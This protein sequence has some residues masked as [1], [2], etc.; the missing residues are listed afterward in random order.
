[1]QRWK[2][3]GKSRAKVSSGKFRRGLGV[4]TTELLMGESFYPPGQLKVLMLTSQG[5]VPLMGLQ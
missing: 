5:Q 2:W 1:M 4:S 3:V